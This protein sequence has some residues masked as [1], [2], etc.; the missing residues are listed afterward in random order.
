MQKLKIILILLSMAMV[1]SC[2]KFFIEPDQENTP[3][4]NFELLW[5]TFDRKYSFFEYK[6]INWD[7]IYHVYRPQINNGI[8]DR[9]LFNIMANMLF[10]LRDG[11]VNLY[12]DF[13]RSRNWEW[14]SDYPPNFNLTLLEDNYLGTDFVA[15]GPLITTAIDSIGYIYI[16]SF[17]DRIR[18]RD[19]DRVIDRLYDMKGIIFDVRH[20]SGGLSTNGRLIAGRFADRTHL[21]SYTLYKTGSGHGDFSIPQPNYIV[22]SGE[23]QFL[24]TVVVLSNRRTY[25]AANDFVLNMSVL[26]HVT[27]MGDT[28]GGGGGTPYDYELLNGWTYRFPRTQTLAKNGF[29]VEHGLPPEIPVNLRNSDESRGIDTI[30]E[31]AIRFI[32]DK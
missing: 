15:N 7:S 2:E 19:I 31:T 16:G 4:N 12:S 9:N 21:S 5:S 11:H 28:T 1:M 13:D 23:K 27:L 3:V 22:P 26:P 20:N 25:S 24:K 6:N 17:A 14:Y 32:N 8:S 10:E 29:N 30:I 18:E